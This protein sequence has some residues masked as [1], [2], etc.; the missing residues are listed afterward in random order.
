MI[1]TKELET[2]FES[3]EPVEFGSWV[4]EVERSLFIPE[5]NEF[6]SLYRTPFFA[7]VFQW[8][9]NAET[10]E[11][12]IVIPSQIGKSELLKALAMEYAKRYSS[13]LVLYYCPTD[14]D[15][16]TFVN[17]KLMPSVEES[18]DYFNLVKKGKHGNVERTAL[19]K[20]CVRFANG[21]EILVLGT[22]SNSALVSKTSPCVIMDEYSGMKN[23]ARG[24]VYELAKNRTAAYSYRNRKVI[25]AST[26]GEADQNIDKLY[27]AF[28]RY[29]WEVPC[30]H[31][32][33]FQYLDFNNLKWD[34]P[35]NH[36]DAIISSMLDS[37]TIPVYYE[38]P[39]C[40]GH[41][42]EKEKYVI[43]NRGR[44][45]VNGNEHLSELKVALHLNGLYSSEKWSKLA[46]LFELTRDDIEAKKV[47]TNQRLAAPWEENEKTKTLRI[48]S[49]ATLPI[50]RGTAP[51]NTYKIVAGM[52]VQHNRFYT[53]I[54]AYTMDNKVHL[55]DWTEMPFN[56]DNPTD[57]DSY[58]FHLLDRTYN[59][60]EVDMIMLDTGDNTESLKE[61]A[62]QLS[63]CTRIKGMESLNDP[64]RY[65]YIGKQAG[66]LMI[67][68]HNTNE[69]IEDLIRTKR[70]T[71]PA[72]VQRED[73][74]FTH[75]TNVIKDGTKYRDKTKGCRRDWRD[76]CRYALSY[77]WMCDFKGE[78]SSINYQKE[79]KELIERM[80]RESLANL[81]SMCSAW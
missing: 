22:N 75:I 33:T 71:I 27:K 63:R 14:N 8:M 41:I 5:S 31:C 10:E 21:S 44:L 30:P 68:R 17:K 39:H 46:S 74:F 58:P 54:M 55:I 1:T 6:W 13:S 56:F 42:T 38:C 28:K 43:M 60:H 36:S 78:V 64:T 19:T 40:Q 35:E 37:G 79:N 15:A 2:I 51:E 23:G 20:N 3:L 52:D 45:V 18:P 49:I 24:D 53:S 73:P 69:L 81:E 12:C 26:P 34:R 76:A 32:G 70:F 9:E 77:M 50:E 7:S 67:P 57:P 59:G 16:T 65:H 62:S 11:I 47:F 61:L 29:T 4:S 80:E 72:N 66:L 48:S 25:A